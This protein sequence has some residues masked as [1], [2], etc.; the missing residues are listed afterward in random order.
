[1]REQSTIYKN[2]EMLNWTNPRFGA[3]VDPDGRQEDLQEAGPTC[4][5]LLRSLIWVRLRSSMSMAN[6]EKIH[7][8]R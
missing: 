6:T 5:G 4:V 7:S 8:I 3:G 2:D 1:M